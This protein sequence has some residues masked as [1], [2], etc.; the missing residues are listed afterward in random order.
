MESDGAGSECTALDGEAILKPLPVKRRQ[1]D[2]A[3]LAG[4]P[5]QLFAFNK[6]AFVGRHV[7][8]LQ[9]ARWVK[10]PLSL[11][12]KGGLRGRA[13]GG[14]GGVGREDISKRTVL[15]SRVAS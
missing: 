12:A 10:L 6:L 4:A 1:T 3:N 9:A 2:F 7:Q 8:I 14:C 15:A 11:V 13:D 5:P